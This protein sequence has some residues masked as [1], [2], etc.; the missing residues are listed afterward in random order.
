[1][2]SQLTKPEFIHPLLLS[3]KV[4][5]FSS[6]IVFL[7]G[8]FITWFMTVIRFKGKTVLET[9]FL[10]PMVLPPTVVGFVLLVIFGRRTWFGKLIE[11]LFDHSFIFS[12]Y[13]AVVAAVVVAFPLVYQ[14][15]KAGFL[16][17]ERELQDSARS[18]GANEWQVLV[19]I[20]MPLSWRA[21][22]TGYVLGFARGLGEFGATLMVAGNIPGRTQ[23]I[24]TGIYLAVDSGNT[25]LAWLLSGATIA[26][27]FGML[28]FTGKLKGAS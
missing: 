24:P 13:A 7:L 23:T 12:W 27:S 25:A 2:A 10:L 21:L 5:L 9:L 11:A 4:T 18:M 26:L 15:L 16:S 22:V 20:T 28:L 3:L 19:H 6:I 8:I 1:M 14:S 17:V